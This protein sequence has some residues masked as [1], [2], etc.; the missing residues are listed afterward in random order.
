M[1]VLTSRRL[2]PRLAVA[3]S[4]RKHMT[5][6][7]TDSGVAVLRLDCVGEKQNTLSSDL[8]D[9]FEEVIAKVETDPEVKAAVLISGKKDSWIAGANIK[10]IAGMESAEA[11]A[12]MIDEAQNKFDRI[13][14]MQRK[15]PWIAAIDG[16]CLG[17]GLEV[18]LTCAHRIASSSSKTVL[19]VPEVMLGLLPG[20]G[21]TQRL[22]KLVGAATALDMIL[23]GKNIKPDKARKMGLVDYVV[24]PSA[25]ERSAV[26]TALQAAE[27]KLKPKQRKLSWME[28]ALEKTPPGRALMF[29]QA[30]KTVQKK[31][32]G[33]Y[34][35]L[36]AILECVR[37]GMEKGHRA[38][39]KAESTLFAKLAVSAESNALRGLFFGQ[40]ATKKNKFGTPSVEVKTLG[41]LGAGLMGSGIA[42]ISASKSIRTLLKD[43]DLA[44]L[45]RGTA[46]IE[47]NMA[48]K[49]KKRRQSQFQHDS[50]LANVV[51]LTD[52]SASWPRHFAQADMVIEAVFEEIG[53]KHKV[54]RDMEAVVPPHCIIATNTSTLL[55][56][57]IASVAQ[58]PQNV[59]GMH[60]FSPPQKMPL[61]EVILHEKTDPAVAAA[62]VDVGMKQGKTVITVKDVPGFYVNRCLGPFL[63]EAMA[64]VQQGA[65][66]V[67]INDALTDF[68]FPVGGITLL[69]EVGIDVAAHVVT[70][71][72][73]D[74]P[75]FLGV[76]ATGADINM[77]NAFVEAGLLGRKAGKG[78]FLYN[79]GKSNKKELNPEAVSIVQRY[80][81]GP[82]LAE[83]LSSNELIER[84]MMRFCSEAVHCLESGVISTARDGDIGAVF[85]IGFPPF[86]GGPFMYMDQLGAKA[87]VEKM[88]RLTEQH[89]EQFAPPELLKKHAAEGKPFH[90]LDDI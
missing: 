56:G 86:L 59:V 55:V 76:R 73:G 78:F 46:V 12:S 20:G 31:S 27:G 11:A 53:V 51:G 88:E 87:V 43:K 25:L 6:N 4:R 42:E 72:V 37:T 89:G 85:G 81:T 69:D 50:T 13:A 77:I 35:A 29:N 52:S 80:R 26:A 47:A 10:M 67:K 74:Q 9:E 41:V 2:L 49:L 21:G 18:A 22:P 15:K 34:P 64:L 79:K 45:T 66:P 36:D 57:D 63:I 16:P 83:K 61:L 65:D 84:L 58:R 23:T 54:V 30:A 5:V 39:S 90:T 62:A 24:D 1:S 60:Y 71:L 75:K 38:G 19:G 68:G 8:V 44:G 14:N 40:T 82:Q 70:N 17:G 32:K 33:K 7:V 3:L 28:W 48:T